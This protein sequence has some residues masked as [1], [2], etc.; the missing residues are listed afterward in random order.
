M[1]QT[2]ADRPPRDK[3]MSILGYRATGNLV[4]YMIGWRSGARGS[5]LTS[6]M[7]GIPDVAKGHEDGWRAYREAY[8]A[9]RER[10]GAELPSHRVDPGS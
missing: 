7:A 8:T 4:A 10:Y 5:L 6:Y 1:T 3:P 2:A 9:A